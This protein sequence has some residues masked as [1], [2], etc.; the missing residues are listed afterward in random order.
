MVKFLKKITLAQAGQNIF[1]D[2]ISDKFGFTHM[3]SKS[4][5]LVKS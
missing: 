5:T 3:V 2:E 4:R 1:Q